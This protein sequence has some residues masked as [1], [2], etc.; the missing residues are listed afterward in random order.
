VDEAVVGA[1]AAGP[2]ELA[3]EEQAVDVGE[4]PGARCL[5][6]GEIAVLAASPVS[7]HEQTVGG[8]SRVTGTLILRGI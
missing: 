2:A 1:E 6:P 7:A 5:D 8:A 3:Q 4:A